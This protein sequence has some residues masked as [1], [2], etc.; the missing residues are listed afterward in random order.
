MLTMETFVAI[1]VSITLVAILGSV[2]LEIR[3]QIKPRIKVYFP[4]G[5]TQASYKSKE[6]TEIAIHFRN[7]GRFAFPKPAARE[8]A[9]FL[10][11]PRTFTLKQ[12]KTGT[13]SSSEVMESPSAGLFRDLQYLR[14]GGDIFLFHKEE[15]VVKALMVMSENTGMY[16]LKVAILSAQGDLGVHRLHIVV[17]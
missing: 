1:I 14:V 16:T 10:Y 17:Y 7:A 3:R 2:Y 9:I 12:I 6:E 15:E 8:L 11:A 4:D 13:N 5:S